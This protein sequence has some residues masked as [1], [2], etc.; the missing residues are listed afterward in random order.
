MENETIM[1]GQN[2]YDKESAKPLKVQE[3]SADER[4]REKAAKYGIQSLTNAECLAILM[5]AGTPGFPITEVCKQ[6]MSKCNNRFLELERLS[7][8]QIM[9]YPGLGTVK[10]LELRTMLEIMRRYH[11]ENRGERPQMLSS[12]SIYEYFRCEMA[13]LHYE[14]MRALFMDNSLRVIGEMKI[15]EG[16]AVSSIFDIKKV[17]K[18]ALLCNAQAVAICHNHPSGTCKPSGPDT[19]VTSKFNTAC[20]TME[21]RFLDHIIVTTEGYYSFADNGAI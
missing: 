16:S 9:E 4:P 14:E 6:I 13:N 18:Q 3:L 7:D 21:L 20:K 2:V 15:S 1:D 12:K 19:N 10:V 8:E 17:L 11:K 5:R